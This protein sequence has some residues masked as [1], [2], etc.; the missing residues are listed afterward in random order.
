MHLKNL[1]LH[2]K[3]G[4]LSSALESRANTFYNNGQINS[5]YRVRSTQRALEGYAGDRIS[6]EDLTPEWLAG[7]EKYW[8]C[9]GMRFTSINIYMKTLKSVVGDCVRCGMIS[10]EKYP[11]G[12]GLYEI[13]CASSRKLALTKDQIAKIVNYSGDTT[14]EKYRDL[15]LFSYLCNGINFR[16]ML[17]LR[18]ANIENDDSLNIFIIDVSENTD[19][20]VEK[21]DN[22]EKT[23]KNCKFILTSYGL[24]TD[25][26]VKFLRKSKKDFIEKPIPRSYFLEIINEIINKMTSEQDFSG[27]GKVIAIY[28]NKGGLGKTT[29]AVNLAYELSEMQ[30]KDKTALVDMNMFLGD[31]TTFLDL[32]PTYD[33][34]YLAEKAENK[35]D[36]TE[37]AT[38]YSE[39]NLFVIADSPYREFSNNISRDKIVHLFNALRKNY[40]FIFIYIWNN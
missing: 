19:L 28:S 35:E 39:S 31:V 1:Y 30:K 33:M 18:F 9:N 23:Y 10:K 3:K 8:R 29:V 5:F 32:T 7:A 21:I 17:F 2:H 16:D 6:F 24:K 26:I 40:K 25:Y 22:F 27:Q 38:Q 11:F 4:G 14:V 20:F 12:R 13:P 37:F 34:I 15:W 36:I